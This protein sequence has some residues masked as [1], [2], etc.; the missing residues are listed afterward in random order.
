MVLKWIWEFQSKLWRLKVASIP[1]GKTIY[2][3]INQWNCSLNEIPTN[4][5]P[6]VAFEILGSWIVKCCCSVAQS[7]QTLCDP[8]DCSTPSFPVLHYLPEFAQTHVHWVG[9][10]IQPSYPLSSPSP[11]AL[12]L[13]Q[14]QGLSQW[15]GSASGGQSIGASASV[16]L[17]NIQG[18][19][20]LGLT[21]F[22][23]LLSK[24][25][26]R[27]FSSTKVWRHQFFGTKP[28]L[29]SSSHISTW[30]VEKP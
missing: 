5:Q 20:L 27:V 28:F 18:W 15:V 2:L 11:P 25:L 19:F 9:D 26:S 21:G 4:S 6:F 24:G 17:M 30:L 3:I 8:M 7:C 29:L 14:H 22:I 13:S 16:F 12:N 10:S 1:G 23:S